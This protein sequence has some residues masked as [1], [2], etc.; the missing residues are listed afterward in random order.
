MVEGFEWPGRA[1]GCGRPASLRLDNG[2]RVK[3]ERR[4]PERKGGTGERE[5]LEGGSMERG[6]WEVLPTMLM[7][8]VSEDSGGSGFGRGMGEDT[9]VPT[10][11][12]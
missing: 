4:S 3:I 11:N 8:P 2:V 5:M 6:E 1:Y 10:M 12:Q 7:L 9:A